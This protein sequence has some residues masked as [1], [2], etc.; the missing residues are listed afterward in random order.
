MCDIAELNKLADASED[1]ELGRVALRAA[2]KETPTEQRGLMRVLLIQGGALRQHIRAD[3]QHCADEAN[4]W[5]Q[6]DID[7]EQRLAQHVN[8]C[9]LIRQ[10]AAPR[11]NFW[12]ILA[13]GSLALVGVA[14]ILDRTI[15]ISEKH[16][17][18][19]ISVTTETKTKP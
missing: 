3:A 6:H 14:L 7:A 2:I 19:E 15:K 11:W 13:L 1:S 9:A 4:K 12:Q 16:N 17:G 8:Q 5:K 10:K 18:G